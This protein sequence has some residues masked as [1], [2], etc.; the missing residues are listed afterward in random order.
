MSE[1]KFSD[2]QV[3]PI[4]DSVKKLDMSD[5]MYFS[6]K[7]AQYI[8]NSRLKNINPNEGGSPQLYKNPPRLQTTSLA[9][10][11]AVHEC[12]LQPEEFELAPKMNKPTAKLGAVV[13]EV[14]KLRK[15]GY[16]IYNAIHTACEKI[17]YYV[18]SIDKKI[19]SIIEKGFEYYWKRHKFES[20]KDTIFLSDSD[21]DVVKSCLD[22]CN[23]NK[24]ITSKLHPVDNLFGDPI[25]SYNEDALFIDFL[26]TY[27][28]KHC[29]TL[30]FK[31]KAD[32]WTIDHDAKV[33]TLNDLKTTGKPVGWFMA[34][35][36]GSMVK[37][38]YNRQMAAYSSILWYYCQ[39]Q[40]GVCKN[41]GWKM[42]CNML[43]VETLPPYDSRCYFVSQT[44]LKQGMEEF[45]QL[46]KRVAYHEMFGYEDEIKFV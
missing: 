35:E 4:L 40:F 31:M 15:K 22:S 41:T 30:K 29:V 9:I 13:D 5:E 38:H 26:V 17:G 45:N 11:S 33:I 20:T 21:Y 3:I 27:K 32:N 2:F 28:K 18:N 46:L 39:Q 36:Y 6:N 44:Q 12:L 16:S 14:F 34:P 7:F 42:K 8:S 1:I 19:P 23:A 10:G 37:Y 43:V 24:Q 25:D